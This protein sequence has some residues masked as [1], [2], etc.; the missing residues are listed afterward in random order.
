MKRLDWPRWISLASFALAPAAVFIVFRAI[1]DVTLTRAIA[2]LQHVGPKQLLLAGLC[3][4]GSYATLTA[5]DWLGTRYAG[6]DLRYSR[7]ALASFLGLSIG[8]TVGFAPFSS[9]AIRYRYYTRWGLS[10]SQIALIVLFSAVTVTVGEIGLAAVA[11]LGQP[12]FAQK[13]LATDSIALS[14]LLGAICAMLIVA[15]LGL[16]FG[17]RRSFRLFRWRVSTPP[18]R[19]ALLQIAAGLVNYCLVTLALQVLLSAS[20]PISFFATAAAYMLASV[21]A[22]LS[23]IPGGIGILEATIALLLPS[24]DVLGPLIAFRCVYFFAP[25]ALGLVVLAASELWERVGASR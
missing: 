7:V 20:A 8:H 15:Y 11:L 3:T 18:P 5:F 22:L 10:M 1:Q 23:H 21:A 19:L 12:G 6:S 13:V 16:C 4:A 9:G 2:S 14:L 17:R 24:Q 25:L